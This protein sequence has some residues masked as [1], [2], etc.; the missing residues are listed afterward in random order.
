[1]GKIII[2][3]TLHAG[4]TLE[5]ELEEVLERYNP[6]QLLVEIAQVDIENGK[7]DSYPPEMVFAYNWAKKNKAKV[8]GFD[9]KIDVFRKGITEENNQKVI[10]EQKKLMK[11]LTWRDMNKSENLKK[12]DTASAIELIDPE[13]EEKR[14]FEMLRN[15]QNL[16]LGMGTILIVTGCGHLDFFEKHIKNA[17]FPFR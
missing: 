8:N 4:L 9:S 1:M 10:K 3:G 6:D 13:K 7:L 15:I 12:L 11:N 16:M 2:V 5:N 17:I 14:E